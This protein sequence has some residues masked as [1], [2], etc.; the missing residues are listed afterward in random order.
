MSRTTATEEEVTTTRGTVRDEIVDTL[1]DELHD[2]EAAWVDD[3]FDAIISANWE[4][5]P[6]PPPNSRDVPAV[7]GATTAA[8]A[9]LMHGVTRRA[10]VLTRR[11]TAGNDPRLPCVNVGSA[12]PHARGQRSFDP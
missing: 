2:I 3:E 10:R 4:S 8:S 5:E 7:N 11:S 1:E 9:L 6:P 12:G